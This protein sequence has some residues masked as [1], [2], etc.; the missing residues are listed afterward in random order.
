M[1]EMG[2]KEGMWMPTGL[3][4]LWDAW[5]VP[6]MGTPCLQVPLCSQ[7]LASKRTSLAARL[8]FLVTTWKCVPFYRHNVLSDW[9]QR[10]GQD[11]LLVFT[12]SQWPFFLSP[13]WRGDCSRCS[14]LPCWL[15]SRG[16]TQVCADR[17]TCCGA[18]VNPAGLWSEGCLFTDFS[19]FDLCYQIWDAWRINTALSWFLSDTNGWR[20]FFFL[21]GYFDV[22]ITALKS[23]EV[24]MCNCEAGMRNP[25]CCD[26]RYTGEIPNMQNIRSD[27][28]CFD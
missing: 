17:H 25:C 6:Q 2:L 9:D 5:A 24:E 26:W 18:R 16:K 15:F 27:L 21:I 23:E 28:W 22:I 3:L 19:Q 1:K 13:A 12:A 7:H 11:L 20:L 10:A 14:G 8:P 4:Q